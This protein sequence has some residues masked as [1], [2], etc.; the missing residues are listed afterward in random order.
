MAAAARRWR[1]TALF[2][3][4]GVASSSPKMS[5]SAAA[6]LAAR[7]SEAALPGAGGVSAG[8]AGGSSSP[9]MSSNSSAMTM[10][11][12][13]RFQL[14]FCALC[15]QMAINC[16]NGQ[17][18]CPQKHQC[19]LQRTREVARPRT[20]ACSPPTGSS[21]RRCPFRSGLAPV[22]KIRRGQPLRPGAGRGSIEP[23]WRRL[24]PLQR[25]TRTKVPAQRQRRSLA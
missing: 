4:A 20:Q 3:G 17:N 7:A 9:N 8:A 15:L 1:L 25:K 11:M 24:H 23:A 6:R 5:S 14:L 19:T 16:Q 18:L 22:P 13:L 10:S 21:T 12:T 2:L